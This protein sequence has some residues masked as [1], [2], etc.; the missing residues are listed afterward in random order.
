MTIS[1]QNIH[2]N[3]LSFNQNSKSEDN[4]ELTIS[5][6]QQVNELQSIDTKVRAHEAAHMAAGGGIVSG[7]ASFTYQEGADGKMY[8]IGG[9]V[10]ISVSSDSDPSNTIEKMEK[11]QSAALAPSDPSST[12]IKVAATASILE[13]KAKI[14]LMKEKHQEQFNEQQISNE[15]DIVL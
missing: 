1:N 11:V 4:Q 13:M 12:D 5:E 10:P 7:G 14:E 3:P 2:I 9:E 8:A 15:E 6:Q